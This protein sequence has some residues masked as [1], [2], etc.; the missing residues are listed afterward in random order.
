VD[1]LLEIISDIFDISQFESGSSGIE[2]ES[3]NVN[4][5]LNSLQTWINLEKA[6]AGKDDIVVILNR[7]N[8][9]NDFCIETDAYKLRRALSHLVYNALKYSNE[10]TIEIGYIYGGNNTIDFYVK[11]EGIG[12]T[13]DKLDIIFS[14]FRQVDETP[15]RQFGGLGLGLTVAQKFV[16]MLDGK[17]WAESEPS[18]GSTFWVSLPYGA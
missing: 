16:T 14:Q 9:D 8:K 6:H 7:L 11:D 18:K 3:V 13:K 10:G 1:S 5:L 4:E 2:F 17:L 12:F 15:T